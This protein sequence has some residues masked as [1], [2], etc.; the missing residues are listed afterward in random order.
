MLRVRYLEMNKQGDS[1]KLDKREKKEVLNM[2]REI[3]LEGDSPLRRIYSS[4]E[5]LEENLEMT[6]LVASNREKHVLKPCPV[7]GAKQKVSK[8][9]E[10][11]FPYQNC[12]SCKRPFY[13]RKD[14]T[15]RKLSEDEIRDIPGAWFRVVEDLDRKRVAVVF[16]LE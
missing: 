5:Q 1:P 2:L 6:A 14:L 10:G 11:I 15:V 8:P 16:K 4:W 12:N 3:W 9:I 7:C 13:V